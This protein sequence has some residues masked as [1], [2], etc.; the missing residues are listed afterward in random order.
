MISINSLTDL[1]NDII[2]RPSSVHH[3][4]SF[5]IFTGIRCTRIAKPLVIIV[6]APF[7][8]SCPS[9]SSMS[10]YI[11]AIVVIF[12]TIFVFFFGLWWK[13]AHRILLLWRQLFIILRLFLEFFLGQNWFLDIFA[14]RLFHT[15]LGRTLYSRCC[16]VDRQVVAHLFFSTINNKTSWN[17]AG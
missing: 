13:S 2:L 14:V 16:R 6:C 3:K 5:L 7:V 11:S 9:F 1:F 15:H 10:S 4:A 17:F 12:I 8:F